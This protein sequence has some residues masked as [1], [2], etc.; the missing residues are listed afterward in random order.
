M[1]E[2]DRDLFCPYCTATS[3]T[4]TKNSETA[5]DYKIA[6]DALVFDGLDILA[7]NNAPGDW[8]KVE[9]IDKDDVL[10]QGA[11]HIICT[12]IEKAY[13]HLHSD[14]KFALEYWMAL[15]KDT[16]IRVTYT[17]V[18]TETDPKIYV[19]FRFHKKIK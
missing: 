2:H 15:V 17:S 5:I 1:I 6:H 16:F 11:N 14:F 4:A 12:A 3:F 18:G 7:E 9:F 19:N 10:G 8:I 13:I